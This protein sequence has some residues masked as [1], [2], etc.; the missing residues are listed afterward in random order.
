M[1]DL[2]EIKRRTESK[3]YQLGCALYGSGSVSKLVI[4]EDKAMATVAGQHRYHVTLD[5]STSAQGNGIQVSCSCP[6]ADYQDIC[7]HAVAVALQVENTEDAL[8]DDM[9][10]EANDR[11]ALKTW[12]NK[13]SVA[14]LTDI[15]F[16]HLDNEEREYDKWLLTME[17][18]SH[19]M[20]VSD[21]SKLITK[22]LPNRPTWEWNEVRDYFTDAESMFEMIF[23]AIDKCTIDQQW[24]LIFK[25]LER[26]NKVIE[27]IDDS[28]GFRLGLE[29][30]L[31]EKI[32]T[33][34]NQLSWSDDKKSQWLFTHFEHYKYDIFPDVPD[35]FT[36]TDTVEKLF[37]SLCSAAV[38]TRMKP[39]LDVIDREQLWA[40]KRLTSVLI[41][42]AEKQQ[43]WPEKCRLMQITAQEPSD[44]LRI[45][46]L[47]LQHTS[48]LDAKHYLQQAYQKAKT[49]RERTE[50]QK[51]EIKVQVALAEYNSAWQLAWHLFTENPSFRHFKQL[52]Q[53]QL[54]TGEID[55]DFLINAEQRLADCYVETTR[56]IT[57]DADA[58]LEFY[59]DQNELEKA[60]LWVLSH[61]AYSTS[62][63]QLADLII[64]EYPQESVDLY[65]R[66][67]G[68]IINQTSNSAYQEAT[69]LLIKLEKTLKTNGQDCV[70]LYLMIE[71]IIKNFKQKRNM[72]KLLR[73][74]F[75]QCF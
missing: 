64:A 28:G 32:A 11:I 58:L 55:P 51:H 4:V 44:Y 39:G 72:M 70:T 12:F 68:V 9:L 6:A 69:R 18:E 73:E 45:S 2:D 21:I 31:N 19:S 75:A 47:C 56:G 15:I 14:E 13:K 40:V 65:Y 67:L 61:K 71:K 49:P 1:F 7:K 16:R 35:D 24:K 66:V 46:E 63:L 8:A 25:A 22:A 38:I 33:I 29:E 43:D 30:M 62:L 74:Y 10:K 34:F 57:H 26:L 52:Q 36:L 41:K 48:E 59:I 53:L 37:L 23:P 3:S 27:Q 50:C 60:R 5:N 42:Q 54:V 20:G 17:T